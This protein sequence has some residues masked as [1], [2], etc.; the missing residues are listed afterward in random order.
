LSFIFTTSPT[1]PPFRAIESDREELCRH[2]ADL[3][4]MRS[5]LRD[6]STKATIFKDVDCH[7]CRAPLSLPS[8]HFL[9]M[10]SFHAHCAAEAEAGSVSEPFPTLSTMPAGDAAPGERECPLCANEFRKVQQIKASL[11]DSL[12]RHD[13]FIHKLDEAANGFGVVADYLGRG[14]FDHDSE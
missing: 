5:E 3:E 8:L 11:R 4:A 9:C 13:Q 10:H 6:L 14:A 2:E 7:R 1:P 12:A